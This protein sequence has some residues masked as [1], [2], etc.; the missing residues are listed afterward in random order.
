MRPAG[1]TVGKEM[2]IG[3]GVGATGALVGKRFRSTPE[4]QMPVANKKTTATLYPKHPQQDMVGRCSGFNSG[5]AA[6]AGGVSIT[7]VSSM[8]NGGG[9]FG[10]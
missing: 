5:G 6:G 9:A 8:G 2:T 4:I 3:V 1:V 7:G 10:G